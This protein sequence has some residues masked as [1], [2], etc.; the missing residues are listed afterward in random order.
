MDQHQQMNGQDPKLSA[1]DIL[2]QSITQHIGIMVRGLVMSW[3]GIPPDVLVQSMAKASG[4]ALSSMLQGNLGDLLKLRL[5]MKNA[6]GDGVNRAPMNPPA[7]PPGM[8][9]TG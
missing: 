2:D 1:R 7:Q 9:M 4:L 5:A 6:F 8:K 3:P